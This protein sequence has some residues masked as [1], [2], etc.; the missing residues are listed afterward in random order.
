M[1]KVKV[2]DLQI[3][4]DWRDAEKWQDSDMMSAEIGRDAFCP[5][6][7]PPHDA[8]PP[9]GYP[10]G[11]TVLCET[12]YPALCLRGPNR[13]NCKLTDAKGKIPNASKSVKLFFYPASSPPPSLSPRSTFRTAS[14]INV[15]HFW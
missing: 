14:W 4:A 12:K 6:A 8:A 11:S 13:A 10:L 9:P 3:N 7:P 15:L 2:P 1:A 5:S